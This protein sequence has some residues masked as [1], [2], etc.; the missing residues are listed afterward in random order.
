MTTKVTLRGLIL[1][2]FTS[3]AAFSRAVGWS[4][5][6]SARILSGMA[7]PT[8]LDVSAMARVL[9]ISSVRDFLSLFFTDECI[10]S[11]TH[12]G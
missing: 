10:A 12:G 7:S 9:G 4:R 1:T 11:E 3:I 5:S 6:K 8:L 2:N